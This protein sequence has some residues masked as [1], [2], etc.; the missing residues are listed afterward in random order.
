MPSRIL[1]KGFAL[2]ILTDFGSP[3]PEDRSQKPE[4]Q[5]TV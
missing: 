1:A 3:E 4:G 5:L 2:E